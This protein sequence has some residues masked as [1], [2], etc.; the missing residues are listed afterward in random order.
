MTNIIT[1]VTLNYFLMPTYMFFE[2]IKMF[3]SFFDDVGG[4][5]LLLMMI[6]RIRNKRSYK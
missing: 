6:S 2:M 5:Q 3:D 1:A 4:P